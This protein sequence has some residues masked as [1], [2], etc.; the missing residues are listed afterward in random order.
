MSKQSTKAESVE[1]SP[2]DTNRPRM[3][4]GHVLFQILTKAIYTTFTRAIKEAVSNAYDA[5]A[6][7][8]T[9][10][11]DPPQFLEKQDPADL[12][13][14]IRDDGRGMSLKDFWQK[15]ASIDS[16]K[17]PTKKDPS[18]KRY[19]IGKFGIGSF[20]LVPFSLRLTLYS[21]KFKER[22]IRC[23]IYPDKLLA[24][25]TDD[26]QEH[27]GKSI[28]A[29]EI[30]VEEWETVFE[31]KD[32]GTVIVIQGVSGETYS[33]LVGGVGRFEDGGKS[34]FTDA[35]FTTGLK[36][37]AWE[38]NTLLPL[39]YEDD[40]DGIGQKHK[41]Q[42]KSNN[43][44]IR[45]TL[46]E[47][48]LKRQLYS[49]PDCADK[50]FSYDQDGVRAKGVI[51]AIPGGTVSPRQANGVILRLNN[52]GIGHYQ[53]FG[54][55][56][57]ATIRQQITG[58]IHIV[59]GLHGALNAARDRFSGTEYDKLR[60]YILKSLEELCKDAYS[61]W[62]ERR[63][64]KDEKERKE[65]EKK[66]KH[67]F[68]KKKSTPPP[69]P[70]EKDPIEGKTGSESHPSEKTKATETSK[71]APKIP[72]KETETLPR[73][74]SPL[75]DSQFSDP[76]IDIRHSTGTIKVDE[77]HPLFKKFKGKAEKKT[78]EVILRLAHRRGS[79][80]NV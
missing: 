71:T 40:P 62:A 1:G 73:I 5:G 59:Q 3:L 43:P 13:I 29:E 16:E 41:A 49:R 14:Q 8:V 54:L 74:A 77:R 27:V 65:T 25:S 7:S 24:K 69:A 50:V 45:I 75:S 21:K 30:S 37:I 20:A 63:K 18:T 36:E 46:S 28:V 11:F 26:Y 58:E 39:N 6:D 52:V 67:L 57:N 56:R 2:P 12:T 61:L 48:E 19:P 17:D 66:H 64:Q 23:V 72:A 55:G 9:I 70:P 53:L 4:K 35:P 22:P 47:V 33:E 32:S 79:S 76:V 51:L 31:S 68:E 78:M 10:T 38:L 34:I 60:E 42:L 80:R 44:G 15:F